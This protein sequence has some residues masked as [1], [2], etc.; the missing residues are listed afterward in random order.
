MSKVRKEEQDFEMRDEYDF[1]NGVVGKYAGRFSEGSTLIVL[2][3]DVAEVFSDTASVNEALRG[4][5]Q[6]GAK[7]S[8]R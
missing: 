7:G 2:D 6:Q 5:I 3:P 4:L 1:S 8:R